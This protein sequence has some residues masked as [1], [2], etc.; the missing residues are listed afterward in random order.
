MFKAKK[1]IFYNLLTILICFL[2][3]QPSLAA[4]TNR[5]KSKIEDNVSFNNLSH[6]TRQLKLNVFTAAKK[7]SWFEQGNPNAPHQLYL[8]AEPN[9]S[10]CHYLYESIRP[11]IENGSLKVRW[12]MVAFLKPSSLDKAATIISDRNPAQALEINESSFNVGTETGG[13]TPTEFI[14]PAAK[15]V[16][17]QNDAFM[18]IYTFKRTPIIIFKSISGRTEILHGA[19]E[20]NQWKELLPRIG[21]YH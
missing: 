9:C 18:S 13:I 10:A 16:I 6:K 2:L 15:H 8:I 4:K 1:V 21:K 5:T 20:Q 19:P 14:S 7:T 3:S 11:Y 17:L 12:I